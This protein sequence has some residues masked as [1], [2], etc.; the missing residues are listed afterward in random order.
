MYKLARLK[1]ERVKLKSKEAFNKFV[2]AKGE[3]VYKEANIS[4]KIKDKS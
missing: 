3:K 2:L 4:Q 1:I